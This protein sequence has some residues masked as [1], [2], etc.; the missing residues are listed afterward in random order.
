MSCVARPLWRGGR[1]VY[2]SGLENRPRVQVSKGY[3]DF[4]GSPWT[5][6][7]PYSA[8]VQEIT[9]YFFASTEKARK[10]QLVDEAVRRLRLKP[11]L[12]N[13]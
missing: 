6:L 10:I 13:Q 3:W 7:G 12:I 1:V 4:C 2:G 9:A 8:L 11:D 5:I